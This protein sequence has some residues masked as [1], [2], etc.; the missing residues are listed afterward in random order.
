MVVEHAYIRVLPGQEAG[1]EG[2]F[3]RAVPLL[4]SA[5]GCQAAALYLD[6]EH[7]GG[8]LLRVHWDRLEDHLEVFPRSEAGAKFA[9][10]VAHFF[11]GVPEVRHFAARPI[12]E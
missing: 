5:S 4:E 10:E 1:F 9:A 6:V 2:A 7:P 3:A 12:G 8:Y 11:A